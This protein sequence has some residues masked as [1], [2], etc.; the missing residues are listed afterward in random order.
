MFVSNCLTGKT[1][2]SAG[3]RIK[4]RYAFSLK[5][6]IPTTFFSF[7]P[8]NNP[9]RVICLSAAVLKLQLPDCTALDGEGRVQPRCHHPR[10]EPLI[11]AGRWGK[12]SLIRLELG[13]ENLEY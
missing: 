6:H 5:K 11:H 1:E 9:T 2:L 13:S 3:S 12:A 10:R 7:Y 8:L 4:G